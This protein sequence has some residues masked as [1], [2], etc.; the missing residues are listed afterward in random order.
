MGL[1]IL[2]YLYH[3]YNKS[4]NKVKLLRNSDAE[5]SRRVAAC[6]GSEGGNSLPT[7]SSGSS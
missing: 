7:A 2:Y 5:S 4:D 1:A 6:L 3:N